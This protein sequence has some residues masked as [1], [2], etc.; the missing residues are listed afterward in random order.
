MPEIATQTEPR[1]FPQ[2]VHVLLRALLDYNF[3][4]QGNVQ[5][6]GCNKTFGVMYYPLHKKQCKKIACVDIP[7]KLFT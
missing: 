1:D 3:C 5:C 7:H 6:I 4:K 2:P